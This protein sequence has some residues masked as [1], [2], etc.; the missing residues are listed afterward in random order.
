MANARD[1][2]MLYDHGALVQRVSWPGDVKPREGQVH[3]LESGTWDRRLLFLGQSRFSAHVFRN[4]SGTTF[5]SPD[6]AGGALSSVLDSARQSIHVNVYEFSST[7]LARKLI[8]SR[9]RGTD[10]LVLVEGGPVGGISPEEKTVLRMMNGSGIPVFQ[11]KAVGDTKPPYRFDHAKYAIIDERLVLV[12][13]ENFKA[14]GIPMGNYKGNRGW[15]VLLEDEGLAGYFEEVFRYDIRSGNSVPIAGSEGPVENPVH[16]A[17]DSEFPALQFSGATVMPVIS[18]DTSFL[19][20]SLIDGA[21]ESIEIEQAYITNA[22]A[23][24]LNPY[25]AAAVNASRRGVQVRVLLDSYWYNIAEEADNDEMVATINRIAAA[26][27]LPLEARCADIGL[28][29]IEKIHNKG[30][31]VDNSS[32][33]VSSINWNSNSPDFNREAGV[34]IMHNDVARYFRNV[35]EDDWQPRAQSGDTL[36]NTA[37]IAALVIIVLILFV[38]LIIKRKNA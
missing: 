16:E 4:V 1:E 25:L 31:I 15:G 3:Y 24:S 19:I 29:N 2:L 6:S 33:L 21:Q 28:N 34:I 36:R 38:L 35:F 27:H 14:S 22:S 7:D 8:E 26:E 37:K 17:Y 12:T 23:V 5:V 30:V 20:L 9:R 11:M 32:V 10:V 13:S 18:P